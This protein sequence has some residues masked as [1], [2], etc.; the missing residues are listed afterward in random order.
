MF[1]DYYVSS[2][3]TVKE[4]M[5]GQDSVFEHYFGSLPNELDRYHSPFRDFDSSPGCRFDYQD[6]VWKF[7]DNATYKGRLKFNCIQ[8]VQYM[9][10]TNFQEAVNRIAEEVKFTD[11]VREPPRLFVPEIKVLPK[12]LT[13]DNYFTREYGLPLSYLNQQKVTGV[14]R[15]YCNTRK[16]RYLKVNAYYS[17]TNVETL[18]Y[19]VNGKP[20]LYFPGED[21]KYVKATTYGDYYGPTHGEYIVVVEGKKDQMILNYH[22]GLIAHGLQTAYSKP[23]LDT[24]K[25]YLWLDPDEA[26]ITSAKRLVTYYEDQ[27]IEVINI[28]NADQKFDIADLYKFNKTKLDEIINCEFGGVSLHHS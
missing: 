11:A 18:C 6:G 21:I 2:G 12:K 26:G 4:I 13:I 23:V 5:M 15:Y 20:E 7:V 17:P 16:H 24:K 14:E 10:D 22:Y 8:F 3:L 1:D 25:V 19:V 27:G 28:T 9:F